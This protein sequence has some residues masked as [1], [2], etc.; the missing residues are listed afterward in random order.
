MESK[1]KQR[2][3]ETIRTPNIVH[4]FKGQLQRE[5]RFCHGIIRSNLLIDTSNIRVV[6]LTIT[7]SIMYFH[8]GRFTIYERSP[9]HVVP[10]NR[11]EL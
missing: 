9:K 5:F 11:N 1:N 6:Y 10:F 3:N 4:A 7:Q 2:R 8:S